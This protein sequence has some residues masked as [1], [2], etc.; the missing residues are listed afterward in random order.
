MKLKFRS[1][2]SARP[3]GTE[4]P[5]TVNNSELA[6]ESNLLDYCTVADRKLPLASLSCVILGSL[7]TL[8]LPCGLHSMRQI[9][10]M[11]EATE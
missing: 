2:K 4:G 10:S 9:F 7:N 5:I 1:G 8:A 6:V 3:T 11:A